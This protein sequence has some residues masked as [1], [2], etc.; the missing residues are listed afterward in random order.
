MDTPKTFT[1]AEVEEAAR[2]Y[3]AEMTA[4]VLVPLADGGVGELRLLPPED[5]YREGLRQRLNER[6][7]G[8]MLDIASLPRQ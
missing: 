3:D 7:E 2:E 8:R 5:T 6:F 1:V 4:P